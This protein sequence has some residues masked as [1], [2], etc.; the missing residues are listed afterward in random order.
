MLGTFRSRL[1]VSMLLPFLLVAPIL[2]LALTELVEERVL[3]PSLAQEMEDQGILIA[4]LGLVRPEIWTDPGA[5]QAFLQALAIRRPTQVLLLDA[6][7]RLL[8]APEEAPSAPGSSAGGPLFERARQGEIVWQATLRGTDPDVVLDV[9]VPVTSDQGTRLGYVRLLRRLPDVTEGFRQVRHLV[10]GTL[11]IGLALSGL[12]G[13]IL[14]QS[15][16][17]PLQQV[18]RAMAEAPLEGPAVTLP[19]SGPQEVRR[20]IWTFNRLQIRRAEL[21]EARRLLLRSTVHEFGRLIGALQAALHALQGGAI[22]APDLRQEL[23]QGMSRVTG[24]LARLLEDMAQI[25]RHTTAPLSLHRRPLALGPWLR[26][27]AALWAGMAQ[28]RA[29]HWREEI[30]PDL[31]TLQVD[32]ERLAQALGNLV[33]NA[34]KFTPAGGWVTLRTE[35]RNREVWIQVQDTGPGIPPEDMQRL[36]EPFYRGSQEGRPGLGLGLFLARI[37]V[38]SHGG[39]L[40]VES[41][42]G[43]G[44]CFTLILPLG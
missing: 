26:E 27:H 38:E 22:E 30:P 32:P 8:A 33:D 21:E 13:W 1:L 37:I 19:E 41:R 24:E 43:E 39:R 3:L 40:E 28:E 9:L 23:L 31:P 18:A 4:R 16:G 36:F 20:L 44:S 35:V 17:R 12:F 15:L 6:S 42:A 2:G 5:A 10:L 14:V 7:G 25:Y 34:L 29:L 11:G